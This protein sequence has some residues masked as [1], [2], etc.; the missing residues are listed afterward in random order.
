MTTG[1]D[2]ILNCSGQS[3]P[4]GGANTLYVNWFQVVNGQLICTMNGTQ[5]NLVNGIT[6]MSILYGVKAS[7]GA[8]GNNVDTYM[9]A[10]QVTAAGMWGSVISALVQLTFTNPLFVGSQPTNGVNQPT[11]S[12]QRVVSVMNQ[13]GPVG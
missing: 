8:A 13:T 1:G 11:I 9:N 12:L 5:Y 7:A 4:V 2:G 6:N 10:S 3:N